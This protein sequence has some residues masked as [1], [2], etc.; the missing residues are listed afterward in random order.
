MVYPLYF[1]VIASVS[2]PNAIY[3]AKSGSFLPA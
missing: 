2:D 1:I 3:E